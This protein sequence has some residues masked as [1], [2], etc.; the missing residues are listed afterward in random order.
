MECYRLHNL[1]QMVQEILF[2]MF[3]YSYVQD[4]RLSMNALDQLLNNPHI[5]CTSAKRGHIRILY[6]NHDIFCD[7][8]ITNKE[9]V[10]PLLK[11][12]I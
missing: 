8:T 12:L 1:L 9:K 7:A 11:L 3:S 5:A 6:K 2:A 10:N 4:K